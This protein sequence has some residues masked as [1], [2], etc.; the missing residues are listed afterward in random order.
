MDPIA[1]SEWHAATS[2]LIR[3]S[4]EMIWD[5]VQANGNTGVFI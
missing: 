4:C 1:S 2:Q 3:F 5:K